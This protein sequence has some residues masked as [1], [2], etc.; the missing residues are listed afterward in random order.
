MITMAIISG[1][2][3]VAMCFCVFLW[4]LHVCISDSYNHR[5]GV[6]KALSIDRNWIESY[7]SKATP[8]MLQQTNTVV[9][10]LPWSPL[11]FESTG[12]SNGKQF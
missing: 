4:Q 11:R 6:R 12:D 9:Y 1:I 2:I 8:M 5:S 7:T 10:P 3:I